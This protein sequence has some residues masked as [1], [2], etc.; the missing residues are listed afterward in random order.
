[1]SLRVFHIVFIF[2]STVLSFGFASWSHENYEVSQQM[3]DL[4]LTIA[5]AA[6]GVGLIIYGIYFVRK[7]GRIIL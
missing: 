3:T 2:L 7:T 6:T 5:A 1:M 4:V